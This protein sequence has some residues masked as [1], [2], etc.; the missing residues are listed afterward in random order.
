MSANRHI[1]GRLLT[2]ASRNL[3][4]Q[5][6]RFRFEFEFEFGQ[7]SKANIR[8]LNLWIPGGG[9]V[10]QFGGENLVWLRA[11]WDTTRDIRWMK[12]FP[13]IRSL[14]ILINSRFLSETPPKPKPKDPNPKTQKPISSHLFSLCCAQNHCFSMEPNFERRSRVKPMAGQM[15]IRGAAKSRPDV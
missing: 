14:L 4:P 13:Q 15:Q 10:C 11:K 7:E 12:N 9:F 1:E 3:R 2:P 5:D 6:W 8:K